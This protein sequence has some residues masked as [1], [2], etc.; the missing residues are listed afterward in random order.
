MTFFNEYNYQAMCANNK[1][2]C[3]G[4]DCFGLHHYTQTMGYFVNSQLDLIPSSAIGLSSR[5]VC[6]AA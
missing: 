2:V 1:C 6:E 3:I 4:A 5:M